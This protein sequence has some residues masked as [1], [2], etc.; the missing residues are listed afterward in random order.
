LEEMDIL[1]KVVDESARR[2]DI[3]GYIGAQPTEEEATVGSSFTSK[4]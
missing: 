3:E 1:F 4:E 2:K